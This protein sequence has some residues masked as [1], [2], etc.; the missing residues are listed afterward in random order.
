MARKLDVNSDEYKLGQRIRKYRLAKCWTQNQ[1]ADMLDMDRAN[2]ANYEN[3]TKGEMGFRTL[4]KFSQVLG[5]SVDVL[6]GMD[7]PID[8]LV[9][10]INQLTDE[11]RTVVQNVVEGLYLKQ[12]YSE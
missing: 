11:N 6:L 3:G 8:L 10:T 9:E 7:E 2:I 1:L 4:V 5:V 12:K